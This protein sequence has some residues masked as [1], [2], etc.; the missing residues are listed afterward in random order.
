[1]EITP[2]PNIIIPEFNMHAKDNCKPLIILTETDQI[3]LERWR[4]KSRKLYEK[5]NGFFTDADEK[6][7]IDPDPF[8]CKWYIFRIKS[9]SRREIS[10]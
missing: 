8:E 6:Y 9:K 4:K 10:I 2:R 1:M 3:Y 5:F 7:L